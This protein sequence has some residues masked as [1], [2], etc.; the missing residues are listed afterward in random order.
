MNDFDTAHKS[1]STVTGKPDEALDSSQG[2]APSS[3]DVTLT[4]RPQRDLGA[5]LALLDRVAILMTMGLPL[6]GLLVG[7]QRFLEL[8]GRP[9]SR[10]GAWLE[11]GLSMSGVFLAHVLAGLGIGGLFRGLAAWI[12]LH[13]TRPVPVEQSE[14]RPVSEIS[15][16]DD[17]LRE[18]AL[19]RIRLFI[20]EGNWDQARALFDA[21]SPADR[22][23]PRVHAVGLELQSASE[24][25]RTTQLAK[26]EA[27]RQVNDPDRVLELH[28]FLVPLLEN[29]AKAKLE[30]DLAAWFLRL[31]HKRL[32]T[33]KIQTDVAV[34]AGRVAEV[35]GHTV[36]GASLRASLGTLRRSAGLC[37][38]CAQPYTGLGD[39][40]PVC[41]GVPRAP[42]EPRDATPNP[43]EIAE[44]R[45]LEDFGEF[46]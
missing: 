46:D 1:A 2:S 42:R 20:Q 31:I 29:E 16:A 45:D 34:L 12:F 25:A 21:F 27:A 33:G 15:R 8:A 4:D 28:Q 17:H 43:V 32:R 3:S 14:S 13:T 22:Q 24:S 23:H 40:C 9:N 35:F 30:T 7:A 26:L 38:R 37:P 36:E 44:D 5:D 41:L 10:P 19:A 39:A 11:A 6:L 18:E